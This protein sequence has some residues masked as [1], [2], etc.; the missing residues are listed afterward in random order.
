M[1]ESLGAILIEDTYKEKLETPLIKY[2]TQ[3]M[4][5]FTSP[6]YSVQRTGRLEREHRI[7]IHERVTTSTVRQI[8]EQEALA[9]I[10]REFLYK[11]LGDKIISVSDFKYSKQYGAYVEVLVDGNASDDINLW[12]KVLD[13]LR[14]FKIPVF[15]YWN[16]KTDISP[17]RLGIYLA[18]ALIKMDLYPSTEEPIDVIKILEEEWE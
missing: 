5:E 18:K 15:F 4:I 6:E 14:P 1:R 12:L 8:V 13:E 9:D 7:T 2:D 16:C 3:H 10:L 17:E 11:I